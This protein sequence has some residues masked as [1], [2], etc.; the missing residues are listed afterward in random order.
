[1][2]LSLEQYL[3]QRAGNAYPGHH[4]IS[5]STRKS[6]LKEMEPRQGNSCRWRQLIWQPSQQ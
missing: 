6:M 4:V 3:S 5:C 1:M 2:T